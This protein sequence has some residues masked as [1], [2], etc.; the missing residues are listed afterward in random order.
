MS[1]K[2]VLHYVSVRG[3][4]EPVKWLLAAAGVEFEERFIE[5]KEDL[6]KLRASGSLLFQQVPMVEIDGMKLVQTRAILNYIAG[7]YNLYGKDLKERA[8][9]DMYVEGL[10]DLNELIMYHDF[11]P[12]NEK[13]ENLANILDKAANRYLPVFEKVLKDH[14]HDF[15]VGNKLSRADVHLL[16][17]ILVVEEFKPDAL[18][19]FPLLQS[20]KARMSNM[21]N[22]K[23]FL[24]PGS[25][26]KPPLQEKEI[27]NL[28]AIFS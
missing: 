11:K 6:Q 10:A 2:P 7:K 21:P 28:L 8:L 5:T 26:K 15:L 12:A 22:I 17:T 18:A 16:E 4:M 3:R 1:G 14:G 9:I 13:E 27:P 23:K 25:P 24:Q 20:F 19:K